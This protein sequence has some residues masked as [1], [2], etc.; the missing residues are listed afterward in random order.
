VMCAPANGGNINLNVG[1]NSFV[2]LKP[3]GITLQ[4]GASIKIK[5]KTELP[6]VSIDSTEVSMLS[7]KLKV[8]SAV[9]R[10]AGNKV[11]VVIINLHD[12]NLNP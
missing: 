11:T 12:A 1:G 10:A 7:N 8:N 4:C 5:S 9:V 6:D 2:D 3:S